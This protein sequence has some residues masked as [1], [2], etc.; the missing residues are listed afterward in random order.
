MY[1]HVY[2]HAYTLYS[3][4][5]KGWSAVEH[6]CGNVNEVTSFN[7]LTENGVRGKRFEYEALLAR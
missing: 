4:Y 6:D 2:I 3:Q 5:D 7:G 1:I